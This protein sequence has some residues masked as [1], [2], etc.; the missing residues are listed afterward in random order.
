M[1][2]TRI[3]EKIRVYAIFTERGDYG[4]FP[5]NRLRPVI[6]F[7]KNREYRVQD[8]TYIWCEKCGSSDIYHFTV[9]D[10]TSLFELCYNARTFDWILNSTYCE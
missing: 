8:V 3:N 2:G 9:S 5:H 1:A 7:W 4:S 10:G 6:F